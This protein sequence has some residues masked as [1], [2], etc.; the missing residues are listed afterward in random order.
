V[1]P[2]RQAVLEALRSAAGTFDMAIVLAYLPEDELRQFV[3]ALPEVDVVI[4]GPT[5]QPISP[6]LVGP[7]LLCSATN[8]G[9][10]L[11]QL[12]AP[13]PG[14]ADRWKGIIVELNDKIADDARQM[15]NIE[16]FRAELA[17]RDFTPEQTAFATPM[18]AGMPKGF[19]VAGTVACRK[20]HEEDCQSWSKSAHAAAWK[21]LQEKGA[22]VDPECQRCHT[23]GYGLPGGFASPRR[24]AP[25][26]AVGCESC[27]GPSQGHVSE[28][29]VRTA[30]FTLAKN[31][32]TGCHDRENSPKFAYDQYWAKI[33]HGERPA[34]A[35]EVPVPVRRSK[36]KP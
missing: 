22:H 31:Q 4:G 17:R 23:T 16:A 30:H 18:P 2:P 8:K 35:V 33:A 21:V 24:S 13:A 15:A 1:T 12:D 28:P 14:S 26:A 34:R 25:L 36:D 20:C 19:A 27:H 5:G 10:F 11:A 29:A 7:T 6:K 9:K 3:E 32:C